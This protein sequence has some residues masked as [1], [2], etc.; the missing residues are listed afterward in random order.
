MVAPIISISN[1]NKQH[2]LF[3]ICQTTI[4]KIILS[5]L[6]L[7]CVTA[8]YAQNVGIGTANPL[9]KLH[10]THSDSAIA[11][12][13]NTTTLNTGVKTALYF[14]TGSGLTSFTGAVKTIGESTG[15]ARMGLFTFAAFNANG[16][17]ERMS[18]TDV[19]DVG[20]GTI[21]P[22]ARLHVR[23]GDEGVAMFENTQS[24]TTNI[25]NSIYFKT[26]SG[27]YPYT[28]A[29]KTV[30]E[31]N[32]TARLGFFTFASTSATGLLE[33][34]SISDNGNIGIGKSNPQVALDINGNVVIGNSTSVAASGYKLSVEGKIMSEEVRV[35]LKANWPDYVFDKSYALKSLPE[36]EKYIDVNKHL[37]NVPAAA[38]VEKGGIM[39]GD[40]N[41]KLLEKIEELSLYIIQLNKKIVSIEQ[42]VLVLKK[43]K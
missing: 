27:T 15:S 38:E 6:F 30:G 21:S 1:Q 41:G 13:E 22:L 32:A 9:M 23:N 4:M 19:G 43:G 5:P 26:G 31:S 40:M 7:F 20:I 11:L 14:K 17:L 42:E 3:Q 37:P 28:G 33:R 24:L 10:V 25:S 34:M 16:L 8:I 39:L 18:I 2:S 12:L 36:L 29:I 35:L